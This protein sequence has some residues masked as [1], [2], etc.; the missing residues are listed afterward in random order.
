MKRE[1]QRTCIGCRRVR[2]RVQLIRLVRRADGVVA[3]DRSGA[4][5]GRGAYVCAERECV[6][7][8]LKRG[9]LARAFRG[10][11]EASADLA[12]LFRQGG[13]PGK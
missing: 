2:A 5:P 10:A 3:I 9:R 12:A 1:P 11:A 13:G 4:A 6:E 7:R 8:G